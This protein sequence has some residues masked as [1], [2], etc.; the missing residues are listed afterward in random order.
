M[1]NKLV[2]WFGERNQ[3]LGEGKGGGGENSTDCMYTVVVEE[4]SELFF[5]NGFNTDNMQQWLKVLVTLRN[6][7]FVS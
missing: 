6:L 1:H 3:S 5:C 7:R 2:M 4:Q